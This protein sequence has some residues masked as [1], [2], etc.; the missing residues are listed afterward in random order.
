YSLQNIGN[1]TVTASS[2]SVWFEWEDSAGT[3]HLILGIGSNEDIVPGVTGVPEY[4]NLNPGTI[5][6]EA[7][8]IIVRVDPNNTIMETNERNNEWEV[9]MPHS[10]TPPSASSSS[11]AASSST[12]PPA[13]SSAPKSTVVPGFTVTP[14]SPPS[15]TIKTKST[16]IPL[17]STLKQQSPSVKSQSKINTLP[18]SKSKPSVKIPVRRKK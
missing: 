17:P 3:S 8:K 15:A 6:Q 5:P 7:E 14:S 4:L 10:S 13:P 11:E 18:L 16:K 12:Q 1:T 2:V 9:P